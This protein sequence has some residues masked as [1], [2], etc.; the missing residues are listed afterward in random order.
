MGLMTVET[1]RMKRAA[2]PIRH[3][4]S[5]ED[6]WLVADTEVQKIFKSIFNRNCECAIQALRKTAPVYIVLTLFSIYVFP[7]SARQ[8]FH[9]LFE[10]NYLV[11]RSKD[12][13]EDTCLFNSDY[14]KVNGFCYVT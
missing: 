1:R 8:F 4:T 5:S 11:D 9:F 12:T 3:R 14:L 13:K 7:L 10:F 6:H 2:H